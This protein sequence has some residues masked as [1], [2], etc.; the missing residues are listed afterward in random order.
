MFLEFYQKA[1]KAECEAIAD[2]YFIGTML[3][4]EKRGDAKSFEVTAMNMED[5][6]IKKGIIPSM[7]YTFLYNPKMP[8][9]VG[10][11]AFI[12]YIPLILCTS[13]DM[14]GYISGIN[15]NFIPNKSRAAILQLMYDSCKQFYSNEIYDDK[16]SINKGMFNVLSHDDSLNGFL[17][18]ASSYC[19]VNVSGA[20]RKYKFENISKVRMIEYDMWKYI[21][22]FT[23]ADSVRGANIL[24]VQKAIISKSDK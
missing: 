1:N 8:E 18:M 5:T 24:N 15:F 7:I 12:D 21:P 14:N 19:G 17:K 3:V 11:L 22:F 13:F 6:L 20:L 4:R 16:V 9:K 23:A 2:E 10:N